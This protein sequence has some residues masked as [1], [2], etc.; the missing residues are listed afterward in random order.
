MYI[1][2][3]MEKALLGRFCYA[4]NFVV[5]RWAQFRTGSGA[6]SSYY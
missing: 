3:S 1:L 6:L 5:E 2:P 4:S